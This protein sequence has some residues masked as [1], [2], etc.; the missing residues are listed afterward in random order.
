MEDIV[1]IKEY[2]NNNQ[3]RKSFNDL[4]FQ[5]FGINFEKWYEA[6]YWTDKYIPFSFVSQ[7]KVIANVSVN[8]ID[9]VI[10]NQIIKGIQ[11]GT[12][13]THPEY[14]NKGLSRKLMNMVM[15]TYES[16][17]DMMYLFANKTVLDFYPKFGFNILQE[18]QYELEF[19]PLTKNVGA[20]Q[21]L[22]VESVIDRQFIYDFA[23]DRIPTSREFGAV[24]TKELLQ[25]YC[26]YAFPNDIYYLPEQDIIIIFQATK[27][28]IH[29]FDIISKKEVN[30]QNILESITPEQKKIFFHFTVDRQNHVEKGIYHGDEV[31]FVRFK[32]EIVLPEH[33]KHP[34][35][36]QA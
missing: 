3:L 29:I 21:K 9:L 35:T 17:Y 30:L 18:T 32:K 23:K 15:E 26:L 28:C 31:L 25:F 14:R 5:T 34:I 8:L 6:G 19:I 1:F 12:V 10:N 20:L 27:G 13:M 36:S 7:N 4:A 33:F 22:N 16:T 11:I 2:R 24:N